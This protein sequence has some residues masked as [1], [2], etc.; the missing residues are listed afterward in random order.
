MIAIAGEAEV[1][2]ASRR[3]VDPSREMSTQAHAVTEIQVDLAPL[4]CRLSIDAMGAR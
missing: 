3:A 1:V 2:L 4:Y